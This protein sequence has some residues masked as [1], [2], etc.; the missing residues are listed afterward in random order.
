[1][2]SV[3]VFT[4]KIQWEDGG[5]S[6]TDPSPFPFPSFFPPH[7]PL[8]LLL[9]PCAHSQW[10]CN[11]FTMYLSK[12]ARL[13]EWNAAETIVSNRSINS[14]FLLDFEVSLI[15]KFIIHSRHFIDSIHFFNAIWLF[16]DLILPSSSFLSHPLNDLLSIVNLHC[17]IN[18]YCRNFV[19]VKVNSNPNF[20][21]LW[22]RSI[23]F[24]FH[25]LL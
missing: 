24:N 11:E 3:A 13:F 4:W 15:W 21:N 14:S 7:Y 10:S 5:R 2:V 25:R 8:P 16:D 17:R 18:F 23:H 22:K 6:P 9:C 1:M 20:S 12:Q 19:Q